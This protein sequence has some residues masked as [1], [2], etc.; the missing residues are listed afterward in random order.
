MQFLLK[1]VIKKLRTRCYN[2]KTHKIKE[3]RPLF[4]SMSEISWLVSF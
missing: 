4:I 1:I 2:S 3:K